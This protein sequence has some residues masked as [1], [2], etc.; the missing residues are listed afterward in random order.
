ML[1]FLELPRA[2]AVRENSAL[3]E[4]L[5]KL[6]RRVGVE[7]GNIEKATRFIELVLVFRGPLPRGGSRAEQLGEKFLVHVGSPRHSREPHLCLNQRA[8][9]LRSEEP[10]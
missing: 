5:E 2:S 10:P 1:D 9:R 3:R 6:S 7:V 4:S 8:C